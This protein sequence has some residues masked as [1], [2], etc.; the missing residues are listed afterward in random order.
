M[1]NGWGAPP[2]NRG[3]YVMLRNESP[4]R[5]WLAL[6]LVDE[7]EGVTGGLRDLDLALLAEARAQLLAQRRED[8]LPEFE[9]LNVFAY[10][11]G[12]SVCAAKAGARTTSP[13]AKFRRSTSPSR[14][15]SSTTPPL[16]RMTFLTFSMISPDSPPRPSGSCRRPSRRRWD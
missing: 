7:L 16:S 11:C 9:L 10:T 15:A 14:A 13:S 8:A 1:T 4:P 12:F 5:R 6:E 2:F 3:P